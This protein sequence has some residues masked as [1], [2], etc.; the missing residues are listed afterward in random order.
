MVNF[1]PHHLI[2]FG[3][4][5]IS[6]A[7]TCN[8]HPQRCFIFVSHH[9]IKHLGPGRSS[10]K[11]H[12][13]QDALRKS[14]KQNAPDDQTSDGDLCYANSSPCPPHHRQP[15]SHR[16]FT[17]GSLRSAYTDAECTGVHQETAQCSAVR[18]QRTGLCIFRLVETWP[19]HLEVET[20]FDLAVARFTRYPPFIRFAVI[21]TMKE[22]RRKNCRNE[23]SMEHDQRSLFYH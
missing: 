17:R 2:G 23:E 22:A 11:A 6:S 1:M 14:F 5:Q 13:A 7:L 18:P 10:M 8:R 12:D 4:L 21:E 20:Q 3:H 16:C 19:K 15:H 9:Y